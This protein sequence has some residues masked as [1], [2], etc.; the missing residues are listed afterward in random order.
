MK[1]IAELVPGTLTGRTADYDA[2]WRL[3]W[4][5]A[6]VADGA[7]KGAIAVAV[8]LAK[9]TNA[10]TGHVEVGAAGL[11]AGTSLKRTAV[12]T[13]MRE[14]RRR[15]FVL[16]MHSGRGARRSVHR[17]SSPRTT[18]TYAQVCRDADTPPD[19]TRGGC[20][21]AATQGVSE[22]RPRV[23]RDGDTQYQEN[24]ENQEGARE[25]NRKS[26]PPPRWYRIPDRLVMGAAEV[27]GVQTYGKPKE[28]LFA[29]L[30]A[31][32]TRA[33]RTKRDQIARLLAQ[34]SR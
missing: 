25:R 22:R 26:G 3:D 9:H 5:A 11:R 17:L 31:A 14:L 18:E 15:G 27:L 20:V 4:L 16:T 6:I 24:H 28:E 12:L 7:T 23:C 2:I 21:A 8:I 13:A 32:W 10:R 34:D 33:P 29:S 19:E 30:T 1:R